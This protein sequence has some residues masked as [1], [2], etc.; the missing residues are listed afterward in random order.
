[1]KEQVLVSGKVH[2]LEMQDC[3]KRVHMIQFNRKELNPTSNPEWKFCGTCGRH[4]RSCVAF[5][6]DT[7]GEVSVWIP[8]PFPWEK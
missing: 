3:C 2:E 4:W 6:G 8:M 5:M 1:M 7:L